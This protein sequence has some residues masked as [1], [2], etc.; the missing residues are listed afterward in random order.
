MS[1]R[2]ASLVAVAAAMLML[3]PHAC[4][5]GLADCRRARKHA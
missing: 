4:W 1:Q 5:P 2:L 3:A